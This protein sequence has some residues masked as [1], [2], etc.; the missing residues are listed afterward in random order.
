MAQVTRVLQLKGGLRRGYVI[1]V[2]RR[3]L[4]EW[5]RAKRMRAV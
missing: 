5:A 4:F 1:R 2:H 3:L